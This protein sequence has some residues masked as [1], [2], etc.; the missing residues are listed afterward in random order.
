MPSLDDIKLD[1]VPVPIYPLPTKPFSVLPPA[2]IGTG[3]APV[4][5][6]DRSNAKVR[7]WRIVNREVR[8]IAGGRWFAKAWIGD[9][10]SEYAAVSA[11]SPAPIVSAA[12]SG[13]R[14]PA[15]AAAAAAIGLPANPFAHHRVSSKKK[16]LSASAAA[17]SGPSR[18]GSQA[19]DA[20]VV[21]APSKMRTS[22]VAPEVDSI[23]AQG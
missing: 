12:P 17:S 8:G 11:P 23:S 18:S 10:E 15:D 3:F 7:H 9:K 5:P 6:L 21:R 20:H 16:I 22:V 14:S 4:V 13:T 2:K 19:P 1:S